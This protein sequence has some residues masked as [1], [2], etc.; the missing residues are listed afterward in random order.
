MSS[1]FKE[2][3]KAGAAVWFKAEN[4]DWDPNFKPKK[5]EETPPRIVDFG[6]AGDVLYAGYQHVGT[7]TFILFHKVNGTGKKT[8]MQTL[9]LNA[10]C[11]KQISVLAEPDKTQKD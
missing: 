4:P 10:T 3:L 7:A 6:A 2:Y 8:Q 1:E 5:G 9:S 11:V